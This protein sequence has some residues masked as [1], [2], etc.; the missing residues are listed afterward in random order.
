M[1]SLNCLEPGRA[2]SSVRFEAAYIRFEADA[3]ARPASRCR[4]AANC[5][6]CWSPASEVLGS[7]GVIVWN[8]SDQAR[9]TIGPLPFWSNNQ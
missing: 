1:L 2:Q 7:G 9:Y 5:P 3:T 6:W 4:P 8:G